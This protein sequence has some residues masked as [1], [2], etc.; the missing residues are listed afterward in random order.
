M[1]FSDDDDMEGP[2][3]HGLQRSSRDGTLL[4]RAKVKL[5]PDSV[6]APSP[7]SGHFGLS[8]RS[9][10]AKNMVLGHCEKLDPE[11]KRMIPK[12]KVTDNQMETSSEILRSSDGEDL[13]SD[14][15]MLAPGPDRAIRECEML[16]Q[17]FSG[18]E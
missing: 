13:N 8:S 3:E 10:R 11:I 14:G 12:K 17:D 16:R 2:V 18:E 4:L 6:A 9:R 7:N 5:N 1:N 15:K